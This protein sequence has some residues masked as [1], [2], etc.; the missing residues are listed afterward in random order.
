MTQSGIKGH[1]LTICDHRMLFDA[2]WY[3]AEKDREAVI[4]RNCGHLVDNGCLE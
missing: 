2:T 3:S 1:N 4:P